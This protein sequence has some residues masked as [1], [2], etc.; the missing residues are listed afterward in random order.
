RGEIKKLE[1]EYW[2]L[3]VRGTN[4]MTYNQRFQELA[5]MCDKMFP[6]ES[7]KVERYVGGLSDM[8]HGSVKASKPQTMQEAIEFATGTKR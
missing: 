5:L 4:L 6:E 8:I 2:N 7:V 3:K 1:T